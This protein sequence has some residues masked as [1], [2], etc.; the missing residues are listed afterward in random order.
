MTD[1]V[2]DIAI[3]S[4][5]ASDRPPRASA[6]AQRPPFCAAAIATDDLGGPTSRRYRLP[7][8][9]PG[10]RSPSAAEQRGE[11]EAA[12]GQQRCPGLRGRSR[13]P[14][15]GHTVSL[16][17][18]LTT[19]HPGADR[20]TGSRR[21]GRPGAVP[22]GSGLANGKDSVRGVPTS[23]TV[24]WKPRYVRAARIA[25]QSRCPHGGSGARPPPQAGRCAPDAAK[26][27]VRTMIT[28]S[29]GRG[30]RTPEDGLVP[31]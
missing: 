3:V 14:G 11:T 30:I 2:G 17:A 25:R 8:P 7:E 22:A 29:G 20:P 18:S 1:S 13:L 31:P 19:A 27:L 16:Q 10:R 15:P 24:V 23:M 5:V 26:P 4:P 28:T 9:L 12:G 6:F 21:P